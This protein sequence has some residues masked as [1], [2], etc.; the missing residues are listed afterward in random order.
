M[1]D[2]LIK[3]LKEHK[4]DFAPTQDYQRQGGYCSTCWHIED[5]EVNDLDMQSLFNCIE[6]FSKSFQEGGD[7]SWR[8]PLVKS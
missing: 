8:N 4:Q 3:Y 5:V 7:N 2:Q 6:E 1:I